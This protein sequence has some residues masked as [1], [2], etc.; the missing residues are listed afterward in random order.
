MTSANDLYWR[1]ADWLAKTRRWGS[2]RVDA[3]IAQ[4]RAI[5]GA[6]RPPDPTP[7]HRRPRKAKPGAARRRLDGSEASTAALYREWLAQRDQAA[8]E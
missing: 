2:D 4:H 6:D 5:M 1:Y 7:R 3:L 8:P